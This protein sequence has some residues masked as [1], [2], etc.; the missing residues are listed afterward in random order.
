MSSRIREN[1]VGL[2]Y[3]DHVQRLHGGEVG[4]GRVVREMIG[5]QWG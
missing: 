3:N 5:V 2:E 4:V 1:L